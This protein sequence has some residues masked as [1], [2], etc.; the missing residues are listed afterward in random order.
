[1]AEW[2]EP[3][4]AAVSDFLKIFRD[5]LSRMPGKA[6]VLEKRPWVV[7]ASVER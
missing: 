2:E 7:G 5:H 1:M 3:G 6:A 4:A